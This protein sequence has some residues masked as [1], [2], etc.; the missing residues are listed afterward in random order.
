M[1]NQQTP[2]RS[3]STRSLSS[4]SAR[5]VPIILSSALAIVLTLLL[6]MPFEADYR[7]RQLVGTSSAYPEGAAFT[8][9]PLSENLD[10]K[11]LPVRNAG[12]PI[13]EF[14]GDG[15]W[16]RSEADAEAALRKV[17]GSL[18]LSDVLAGLKPHLGW[19]VTNEYDLELRARPWDW[20]PEIK[21][22]VATIPRSRLIRQYEQFNELAAALLIQAG[23]HR[24]ESK[25]GAADGFGPLTTSAGSLEIWDRLRSIR[26]T[27]E[28]ELNYALTLT[29]GQHPD[30]RAVRPATR[31]AL[32]ACA[33]NPTAAW[34]AGMAEVNDLYGEKEGYTRFNYWSSPGDEAE[35]QSVLQAIRAA[36]TGRPD[37]PMRHAAEGFFELG[38]AEW[39]AIRGVPFRSRA[40]AQLALTLFHRARSIADHPGLMAAEARAHGLLGDY[41]AADA[42][43]ARAVDLSPR[44]P[45][46]QIL[47]AEFRERAGGFAWAADHTSAGFPVSGGDSLLPTSYGRE[48]VW[49]PGELAMT[50]ASPAWVAD[51]T[52][53][54]GAGGTIDNQAALPRFREDL[55]A[56]RPHPAQ[57]L[58]TMCPLAGQLRRL[59]L[60]GRADEAL[61]IA[62]EAGARAPSSEWT[63]SYE[64]RW[65]PTPGQLIAMAAQ[66]SGDQSLR[67]AQEVWG[68]PIG[69][70][71][72]EFF[73]SLQNLYRYGGDFERA[74][75]A[76]DAW[77][78]E[79]PDSPLAVDRRGEVQF[80]T[81]RYAEAEATFTSALEKYRSQSEDDFLR[82]LE[83]RSMA[84]E[85]A[86]TRLR[87]GV[88]QLRLHRPAEAEQSLKEAVDH[89]A[90]SDVAEFVRHHAGF[91]RGSFWLRSGQPQK[92]VAPLSEIVSEPDTW[93][94]DLSAAQNNLA[95]ALVLSG[96]PGEAVP[97]ARRATERDPN[98]PI[99]L[100]TLAL[101]LD[102]SGDSAG[103]ADVYRQALDQDSSLYTSSNNR[104]VILAQ[105]GRTDEARTAF[106][107][108]L[109]ANPA[110]AKGWANLAILQAQ[111]GT[112]AGML[113]GYGAQAIA[114]SHDPG[115]RGE[116]FGWQVEEGL[117]DTGIDISQPLPPEWSFAS[118]AKPSLPGFTWVMLAL[119]AVRLAFALGL[120]KLTGFVAERSL[121]VSLRSAP[122]M[123]GR[124]WSSRL[125]A[126]IGMGVGLVLLTVQGLLLPSF[127]LLEAI[128]VGIALLPMI[129]G[130]LAVRRMVAS[131]DRWPS[132]FTW[133]PL[134][135]LSLIGAPFGMNFAPLPGLREDSEQG[136][137]RW[138][139]PLF[140]TCC[141]LIV[142]GAAALTDSPLLR[143]TAAGILVLISTALL[144]VKPMDG[145]YIT[146]RA[147]NLTITAGLTIAGVAFAMNWV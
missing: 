147:L 14:L 16:K 38:L 95:L 146:G 111:S 73:D 99:F 50:G 125:P 4:R 114:V 17:A 22:Y 37:H 132:H 72:S 9:G 55:Y 82:G 103:A 136:R 77:Q 45:F 21:S 131:E 130:Y 59:L 122:A 139:G 31:R 116:G 28:T 79:M 89:S 143:V 128:I 15:S 93:S 91:Q 64:S 66:E 65:C 133:T 74:A 78:R 40:H 84:E 46:F 67:D 98:N 3:D 44:T 86:L 12:G 119:I 104:G 117:Y 105:A 48:P 102:R 20:Y 6:L 118:N 68:Q 135:G 120:D 140:L 49:D 88:T 137:L 13:D 109:H 30:L 18:G 129:A 2:T 92:A 69:Q 85:R 127:A 108:A 138:S 24:Y 27:C 126:L 75:R 19:T 115:L 61:R 11:R 142:S 57:S 90:N 112:F 124:L 60:T 1:S 83:R 87:L 58:V 7:A 26:S 41:A 123:L 94:L 121:T 36:W 70:A 56:T 53:S 106:V 8:P 29:L 33:D 47:R 43:L 62:Q 23:H 35:Y 110:Y 34:L 81:G 113:E 76:I 39:V 71:P 10:L 141:L 63:A 100:E 145:G 134:L 101:A 32:A 5:F 107:S 25:D 80:L 144:P 42:L 54:V 51:P 97:A 96:R 52:Y